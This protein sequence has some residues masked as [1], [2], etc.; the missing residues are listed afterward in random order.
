[1]YFAYNPIFVPIG[2]S[3]E[4]S[5]SIAPLPI[6]V[7]LSICLFLQV[8]SFTFIDKSDSDLVLSKIS[9]TTILVKPLQTILRLY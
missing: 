1:M 9:V 7:L 3:T 6:P 8:W 2:T 4:V 5:E